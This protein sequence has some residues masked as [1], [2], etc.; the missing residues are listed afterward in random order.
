M[1]NEEIKHVADKTEVVQEGIIFLEELF[2]GMGIHTQ[3]MTK[4]NETND[5]TRITLDIETSDAGRVIGKAGSTLN[6]L[7]L[8]LNIVLRKKF[9]WDKYIVLDINRYRSKRE[10][11]IRY[12]VK[13]AI[14]EVLSSK[15]EVKLDP[16]SS[17][18]RRVAHEIASQYEDK[19]IQSYSVGERQDR[20]VVIGMG[21]QK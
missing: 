4:E 6:A 10:Q 1:T 7:Q 3:I 2:E 13:G 17:A 12:A 5:D 19:G 16:M 9:E 21:E 20:A 18:E 8:I 15:E 14:D 11:M